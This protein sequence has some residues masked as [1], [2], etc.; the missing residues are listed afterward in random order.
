MNKIVVTSGNKYT[1]IDI[2][3]CAV[4]YVELLRNEEKEAEAVISGVLNKSITN[5]IKGWNPEYSTSFTGADSFVI[6]DTSHPKFLAEFVEED[7]IIELYDHHTGFEERY[8]QLLGDNC[9]IEPIGACATLIWEQFRE[10]SKKEISQTS[11]RLL[12]AAIVSNSLNFK[13]QITIDRDIIA[14]KELKKY[15]GLSDSWIKK[16]FFDQDE[17]VIKDPYQETI[18]DTHIQDN[19]K[20]VEKNIVIGQLELWDSKSFL[21]KHLKDVEKA[22]TSFGEELWFLTSPS[23]SEGKNYIYTKNDQIKALLK[24]KINAR[25]SGDIGTTDILWLRKEIVREISNP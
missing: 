19:I 4:A 15:T 3:G 1:D 16:Y 17:L 8:V 18:N 2:L 7:K 13:A 22:L 21:A 12:Y 9:H 5:E 24:E 11:A 6:V 20:G 10:R 14:A 25:F 23:I